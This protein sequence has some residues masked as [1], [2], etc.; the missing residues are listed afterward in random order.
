MYGEDKSTIEKLQSTVTEL[1]TL[2]IEIIPKAEKTSEIN[3]SIEKMENQIK[4][5][6]EELLKDDETIETDENS[7]EENI[8]EEENIVKEEQEI[9]ISENSNLN[10][11]I[12]NI[13]VLIEDVNQ[14]VKVETERKAEEERKAKE[15]A[16]KK[17][18]EEGLAK[19]L[20]GD[21]S[22]FIGTYTI[23]N[24]YIT[25]KITVDKNGIVGGKKPHTITKFENGSYFCDN[26]PPNSDIESGFVIFPV[27][28]SEHYGSDTSR[29][30]IFSGGGAPGSASDF[31][32]KD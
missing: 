28:V 6:D 31:Y 24:A 20:K 11:L 16:E 21:F 2:K 27:G 14:A 7:T 18:R 4:Q 1:E 29:V 10:I 25:D 9:K 15:E 5:V 12:S 3:N 30:R 23:K 32:Y 19:L 17:E 8:S 26:T 13:N 22:Y